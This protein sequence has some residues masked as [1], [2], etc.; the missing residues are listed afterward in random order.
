M[1]ETHRTAQ[2]RDMLQTKPED[3]FL[4]YALGLEYA[5]QEDFQAAAAQFETVMRLDPGYLA[6]YYQAG[7]I[8]KA[9]GAHEK[10]IEALIRGLELAQTRQDA[11]T[12]QEILFL[13][14]DFGVDTDAF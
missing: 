10:G 6:V 8:Y 12:R 4:N 11:K 7:L 13:L 3:V 9:L 14:E 1:G 2:L 5:S